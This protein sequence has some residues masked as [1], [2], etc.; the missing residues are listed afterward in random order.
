[1]EN[2]HVS[3]AIADRI[4]DQTQRLLQTLLQTKKMPLN[5]DKSR[6]PVLVT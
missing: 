6:V 1:M 3:V 2:R 5:A 4:A